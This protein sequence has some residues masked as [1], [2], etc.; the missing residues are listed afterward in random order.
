M[1]DKRRRMKENKVLRSDSG[2]NEVAARVER[3][4]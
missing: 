3:G 1:G 2:E 4:Y